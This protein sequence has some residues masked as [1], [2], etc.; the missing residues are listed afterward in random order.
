MRI[1]LTAL[2]RSPPFGWFVTPRFPVDQLRHNLKARFKIEA[3]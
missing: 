3:E 2:N 1:A